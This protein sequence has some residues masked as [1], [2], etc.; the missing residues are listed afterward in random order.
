MNV[1]IKFLNILNTSTYFRYFAVKPWIHI[2]DKD[3]FKFSSRKFFPLY[4][5][6]E[7]VRVKFLRYKF[8]YLLL[9]K[10][11]VNLSNADGLEI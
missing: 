8:L 6:E 9:S 3:I 10:L 5:N 1:H 4:F 2:T 7:I 11:F